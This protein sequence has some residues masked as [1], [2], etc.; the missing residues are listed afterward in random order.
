MEST[1]SGVTSRC[2]GN[3]YANR[4]RSNSPIVCVVLEHTYKHASIY[5]LVH[6]PNTSTAMSHDDKVPKF[7]CLRSV[8][9]SV[10]D[11]TRQT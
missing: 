10:I 1:P 2:R 4:Y 7:L 8:Q 6:E 3:V 11:N 5:I 9:N